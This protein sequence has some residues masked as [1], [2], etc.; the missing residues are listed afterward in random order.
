M[1]VFTVSKGYM[2]VCS[3]MPAMEPA[4][5]WLRKEPLPS[6]SSQSRSSSKSDWA[7]SDIYPAALPLLC[8]SV[9]RPVGGL[10]FRSILLL[11]L[12]TFTSISVTLSLPSMLEVTNAWSTM[13]RYALIND[14]IGLTLG[15]E[16]ARCLAAE[17]KVD[18][19]T[20]KGIRK[21]DLC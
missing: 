19:S 21:A 18:L 2:R 7:W 10:V 6:H 3:A 12:T 15:K 8:L 4:T 5:Q 14:L 1:W 9:L 11:Q 20:I 17:K 13:Y 16:D